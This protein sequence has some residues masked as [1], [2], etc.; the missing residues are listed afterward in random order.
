MAKVGGPCCQ[1]QHCLVLE[2]CLDHEGMREDRHTDMCKEIW[3][4]V[5]YN[6]HGV[7]APT[8]MAAWKLSVYSTPVKSE[9]R[10]LLYCVQLSKEAGL[11]DTAEQENG[12][13]Q[14]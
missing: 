3:D 2:T 11:W 9:S 12:F 10:S 8:A 13:S 6:H 1:D 4:Q 14:S 5:G 7:A